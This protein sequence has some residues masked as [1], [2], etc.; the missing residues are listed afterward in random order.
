MGGS[1]LQSLYNGSIRKNDKLTKSQAV[2]EFFLSSPSYH[3]RARA[4]VHMRQQYKL[5]L[6]NCT[7]AEKS[8]EILYESQRSIVK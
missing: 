6:C 1:Q 3:C 5:V 2:S 8:R 7:M 4:V